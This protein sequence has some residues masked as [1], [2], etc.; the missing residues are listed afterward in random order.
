[1]RDYIKAGDVVRTKYDIR[2]VPS[3]Y[4]YYKPIM[5]RG[6]TAKVYKTTGLWLLVEFNAYKGWLPIDSVEKVKLLPDPKRK[7]EDGNVRSVRD[8]PDSSISV[9]SVVGEEQ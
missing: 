8:N 1:M 3:E 4:Y 5:K 9:S 7:K 6:K 2:L